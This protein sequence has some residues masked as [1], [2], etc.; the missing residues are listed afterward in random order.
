MTTYL[1]KFYFDDIKLRERTLTELT[2]AFASGRMVGFVGSMATESLGYGG[3]KELVAKYIDKA[4][5]RV[6]PTPAGCV[7]DLQVKAAVTALEIAK[8]LAGSKFLDRQVAMSVAREALAFVD[9]AER[10]SGPTRVEK[11]GDSARSMF[12]ERNDSV[13][14]MLEAA[15]QE[16]GLASPTKD[17]I[18]SLSQDLRIRRFATLNYD[19]ELEA[20]L[21]V[22]PGETP[23][24]ASPLKT[25]E[26]LRASGTIASDPD[27]GFRLSRL[28]L[29][30][31]SVESDV[32][33]RLRPDRLID[34]AGGSA[35]VDIRIM[36]LH[37]RALEPETMIV[38][39]RDYDLLYRKDDPN[40]VPFEHG[41]RILFAG[42]PVLF[43]GA[44]MSEQELN[45]T[46][47]TFV[48]NNPYRRFAPTFLLWNTADFSPG[49]EELRR[50]QI[51]VKRIDFFR[52]LGVLTIFDEDLRPDSGLVPRAL[53]TADDA[54]LA[55]QGEV[56]AAVYVRHWRDLEQSLAVARRLHAEEEEEAKGV[57]K[58]PAGDGVPTKSRLLDL[59][60]LA[61]TV[62]LVGRASLV[63]SAVLQDWGG[64]WRSLAARFD[65]VAVAARAEPPQKRGGTA[66]SAEAARSPAGPLALWGTT[67]PE[68]EVDHCFDSVFTRIDGEPN[69]P[70]LVHRVVVGPSGSGKGALAW[71][72]ARGDLPGP[73][74]AATHRRL[75]IN[76][77]FAL[78]TDFL[79]LAISRF[80]LSMK[81]CT[82]NDAPQQSR[83]DFFDASE[84]FDVGDPA[85][86]IING[87]ERFFS[88]AGAPLSAELDHLLRRV[89]RFQGGDVRWIFL[90]SLRVE[91]Y[92]RLLCD[93]AV[94]QFK[95]VCREMLVPSGR[96]IAYPYFQH[97]VHAIEK[98]APKDRTRP[99]AD[100]GDLVVLDAHKRSDPQTVRRAVLGAY[101]SARVLERA[102]F[103]EDAALAMEILRAMAFI[104]TPIEAIVLL[105]VPRV[106]AKLV[107]QCAVGTA[108]GFPDAAALLRVLERLGE[109]ALIMSVMSF[110]DYP[111]RGEGI[112]Q[113]VGLHTFVSA[114]LRHQFGVPVSESKLSASFNMS[115]Y[116]A[117]PTDGFVPEPAIHG[118]LGLLIDRLIGAAKDPAHAFEEEGLAQLADGQD[119][120]RERRECAPHAAAALRAALAVVRSYLST[121][122]LLTM[123]SGQRK[124]GDDRDG[125]LLE[126]AERLETLLKVYR[127]MQRA[128]RVLQEGGASGIGPSPF[129]PDDLVWILNELGVVYLAQGDLYAARRSFDQAS[130]VNRAE[131]EFASPSH[132]WRRISIN[133]VLLLI[134]RGG[135]TTA[136]SLL[137]EIEAS[138]NGRGRRR[139]GGDPTD[140][141]A[142]AAIPPSE[143]FDIIRERF[144]AKAPEDRSCMDSDIMHEE[145]LVTG[146]VLGHRG[147]CH[148]LRGNLRTAEPLYREAITMLR[149]LGENRAY[150]YFQRHYAQLLNVIG[151]KEMGQQALT[152][153][154]AA[155]E[156]VRQMDMAYHARI[157]EADAGWWREDADLP[158]RRAALRHLSRSAR[159]A[160]VMDLHR[161]RV[162]AGIHLARLKLSSGDY[163]SAL[164]HAAEAMALAARYGMTLRKIGLRV[165]IGHIL[166]RRGDRISGQALIARAVETADRFGYQRAVEA[167]QRIAVEEGL[168]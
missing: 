49:D 28:M 33:N 68:F 159:Y 133:R 112:W 151:P 48:S 63:R 26:S 81:G 76:A 85:L 156:S 149:R 111:G 110:E 16:H 107:G 31:V 91:G 35:E 14:Q 23:D 1:K 88:V 53:L 161:I 66:G 124:L 5:D 118:E 2:N 52:R 154:V 99:V 100:F 65:A 30:G 11:L 146:L 44:G 38:G 3:W 19:L 106:R 140:R 132:N 162:D 168:D 92:F 130:Q 135:L 142:L 164:E 71:A 105:H 119:A 104:G 144:G 22:E 127:S 9:E 12:G 115:L 122:T 37:G 95:D 43:V 42:N 166:I 148:H 72:L 155:A 59:S 131:V 8:E 40:K 121:T 79:L 153:A 34:F 57:K 125:V 45:A 60:L 78:D 13:W 141:P 83:E 152:L 134:E 25:I 27:V 101:L 18:R 109:A 128:Q 160:A 137:R 90:G 102:G 157:N 29:N 73:F 69:S 167:A 64:P 126:H 165:L 6:P 116:V 108:E 20:A 47:Q 94:L 139:H 62:Q 75:I 98:M 56:P 46:L 103:G 15:L 89:A 58:S 86:I 10:G 80:L 120:E 67:T 143:R 136:E 147:L 24:G 54:E 93:P 77:G 82:W 51:W 117:Q 150:A 138:V 163:E 36:H 113:R 50:R 114:E 61:K 17:A 84:A 21:M 32:R 55:K 96:D 129:Y 4:L 123:D 41:Q 70:E 158:A 74:H 39:L 145:V 7:P 87:M 97:M